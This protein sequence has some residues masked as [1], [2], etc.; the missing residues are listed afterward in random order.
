M[1]ELDTL[2]AEAL[3]G[4]KPAVARLISMLERDHPD[5]GAIRERVYPHADEA[6][7]IGITGPPGAGK[8][9]LVDKLVARFVGDQLS[10]AVIAVDPSSPFTGGALLG[11][12]VRMQF[13]KDRGDC[14]F[15]SMSAGR[16]LGGLSRKS[17]EASWVLAA[18][19]RQVILIETVGVGQSELDILMATDTVV[20]VL[21][22]ES[23]DT[24]QAMKS[25]LV[26]IA[27]LFVINKADRPG[28]D[29][30]RLV[31]ERMLERKE[32]VAGGLPW[33]PPVLSTSADR[34]AGVDQLYAGLADH[35]RYLHQTAAFEKRRDLQYV[36]DLRKAIREEMERIAAEKIPDNEAF[37]QFAGKMRRQH[38]EPQR[39]ARQLV[40]RVFPAALLEAGGVIRDFSAVVGAEADSGQRRENGG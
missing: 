4:K 27:D 2:L 10:V 15:R 25:G 29:D 5:S 35:R 38:R 12:R 28:A 26:E 9:T 8:S 37:A 21:T 32:Q 33:H 23:G 39:I 7:Y 24:I 14:F 6:L 22:P 30:M 3:A 17:R 34:D 19:G 16:V 20:V 11:D 40:G 31:I 36:S 1:S 13:Q 18:S